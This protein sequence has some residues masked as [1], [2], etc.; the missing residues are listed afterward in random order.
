MALVGPLAKV[1]NE[2]ERW[3]ETCITTMLVSG[4]VPMLC[5]MAELVG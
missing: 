3:R 5:Q 1:R 4:P 2:L